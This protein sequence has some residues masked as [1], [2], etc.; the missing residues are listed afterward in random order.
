VSSAG[1]IN[2]DGIDDVMVG[3]PEP[4]LYLSYEAGEG[5]AY[6]F[7]GQP[8]TFSSVNIYRLPSSRGTAIDGVGDV[9]LAGQSVSS[10][11]DVNNDGF[12]DMILSI[13]D[14]RGGGRAYVVFGKAGFS[15]VDLWSIKSSQG[16]MIQGGNL[17]ETSVSSAGDVN[18][19]G[20]DDVIV[21]A[22]YLTSKAYVIF[23]HAGSFSTVNPTTLTADQGFAIQGD[24]ETGRSVS[25][26][27]DVNGDG[28]DD[29]IVGASTANGGTGAAYILFGKADGFADIDLTALSPDDGFV[30]A[31]AAASD[32]AGYS[33]ST[34]GDVTGDGFD[35]VIVGAPYADGHG[36]NTGEAYVVYGQAPTTAVTRIGAAADQTIRGGDFDDTL[37]GLG[38][39]D[40]LFG[41]KGNDILEG[42]AGADDIHGGDGNDTASYADSSA[43]VQ[44]HVQF[45]TATGGDAEGDT[46]D[47]IENLIGSAFGDNLAGDTGANDLH[48][49][50]GDDALNGLGGPDELR[51]EAGDDWLVADSLDTMVS[52][53]AGF[54]RVTVANADGLVLDVESAEVEVVNGNDGVEILDGSSATWAL[55][56]RGNGGDDVL[57]GGSGDDYIYGDTGADRLFGGAGL[58]RLFI[59]ETDTLIDGGAGTA[60]RVI[61]RQSATA[62]TGVTVNM[63]AAHVEVAYGGPNGDTFDGTGSGDALSLYGRGGIDLLTGGKGDDLLEGGAGADVLVGG[64]GSDAAVY[65]DSAAPVMVHLQTGVAVGGDAAGDR[66]SAIEN[67]SGSAFADDLAGDA[68][69]N[70]L[71]GND[72]DDMLNGLGGADELRGEAGDDWLFADSLDTV[73]DGGAGF[74]RVS[75]ADGKG[76]LL[77][78]GAARV[79]LV[80]G[81]TGAEVLYGASAGWDLTLR[82]DGGNDVLIGG[83][84]DDYIYGGAGADLLSGGAGRDRLFVDETDL[85]V[86]G[87]AG[88]ADCV[89]VRQSASATAGVSVAMA[90][91]HVEV[92]FGGSNDDTFD[93]SGATA[94]LCLYGR[95]GQDTLTGGAANDRLFGDGN[96][97]AAGDILNGGG[98][99]DFLRGG[100]NGPGGFAERDHFVFADDWGNDRI[101]DFADNGA[102]KIDFSGVAGIDELSDLTITDGPGF[103]LISYVDTVSAAWSASIRV[104]G[105]TAADLTDSNF[106]FV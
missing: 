1:D 72:G 76:L 86:D 22:P 18:G 106:I 83:S 98:G 29:V 65:T 74:D 52:G 10:A 79:E 25:S 92:A 40:A 7:F 14:S 63:A 75:V 102:E 77:D 95:N 68:G 37:K 99:N 84:G 23:G 30:L 16:F 20:Y 38:G 12:D 8:G 62:T 21:G 49:G 101:F 13:P 31:G 39:D 43:A 97:T 3:R 58:D 34:A 15:Y 64:A 44:V 36:S 69:S 19:D 17:R 80:N 90:A 4:A 48:G 67:L 94:S 73:V 5:K 27:G 42:G 85:P 61:V 60:D 35:D 11:G 59:D 50:D 82:G 91:A 88:A 53:G 41:G 70:V 32:K 54:D 56:L 87:G 66:L 89:I 51:G 2:G 103:A 28:F 33:V 26:A 96:D 93:G 100:T 55:T 24:G 6:V 105:L 71:R 45:G 78:L 46:L 57:T 9:D 47:G 104:D 81:N